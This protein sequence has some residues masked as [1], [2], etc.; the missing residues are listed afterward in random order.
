ML[1]GLVIFNAKE[2]K[3]PPARPFDEALRTHAV[4]EEA[5]KPD[6]TAVSTGIAVTR[7][8]KGMVH[9]ECPAWFKCIYESSIGACSFTRRTRWADKTSKKN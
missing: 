9:S 8:V 3:E 4:R 5:G 2:K 6:P 1:L 7:A